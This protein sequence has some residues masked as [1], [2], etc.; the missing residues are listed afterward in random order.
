MEGG[1]HSRLASD[2]NE[3]INNVPNQGAQTQQSKVILL[4]DADGVP[5]FYDFGTKNESFLL[6][7]KELKELGVKC[8]YFPLE[9]KYPNLGVQNIDPY[10][11]KITPEDIAKVLVECKANPW[12]FFRE[13]VHVPI[14]GAGETPLYLHRAGC[15]AIWCF[16][17]SL[18]FELVQPR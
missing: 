6:T 16:D 18:D 10:D 7:C 5:H 17:H 4:N 11:P 14:R 8:W 3:N 15:A 2:M 9:I 13:C 12:Y 1:S